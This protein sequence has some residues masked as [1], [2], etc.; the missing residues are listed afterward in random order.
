MTAIHAITIDNL[1]FG[2]A[3]RIG[4]RLETL[5]ATAVSLDELDDAKSLWRVSAFFESDIAAARALAALERRDA[6]L[7]F[8]VEVDWVRRSL[9][10]LAPVAA[11]RFLVHGSHDRAR[12][13]A[14]G[15]SLEIDAGTAFGTGHHGTTLGC[16]AALDGL[17]KRTRPR[18]VLDLGCGTGVLAMAAGLALKRPVMASDVDPEAVRV[19]R[20]NAR[21][22]GA[23]LYGVAATGLDHP[24]LRRHAPY[25]L[26]FANILA[27]PLVVLAPAIV[28]ALA[29]GGV[30][31]L[32]GLTRDQERWVGAAYR[33]RGLVPTLAIRFAGWSTLRFTQKK[34][35]R[36]S[37]RLPP[38]KGWV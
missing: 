5:D 13:R 2:E 10:G 26:I 35:A 11:G 7:G 20:I 6:K 27:R 17:L 25:D 1:A 24:L 4:E 32:S 37:G 38:G 19:A 23:R 34:S 28:Q 9:E 12:R 15:I 14:G 18:R 29:P 8:V 33:N 16:L 21:R 3:E 31:V 30:L 22:N 36:R